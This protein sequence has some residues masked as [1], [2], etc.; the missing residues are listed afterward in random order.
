[1]TEKIKHININEKNEILNRNISLSSVNFNSLNIDQS[2]GDFVV[3]DPSNN[4]CI[5]YKQNPNN[6]LYENFE[7]S[8]FAGIGTLKTPIQ[9]KIDHFR[10]MIWIINLESDSVFKINKNKLTLETVVENIENP[11][12]ISIN[13]NNGNVYVK[14]FSSETKGSIY[15]LNPDGKILNNFEFNDEND[16]Y[17]NQII[18]NIPKSDTM[19]FENSEEKLIW[20]AETTIYTLDK[21]NKN[22]HSFI[23]EEYASLYCVGLDAKNKNV[24]VFGNKDDKSYLILFDYILDSV[25]KEE[26]IERSLISNL[27][28]ADE[29][30]IPYH[31][32]TVSNYKNYLDFNFLVE[33]G[34]PFDGDTFDFSFETQ[35]NKYFDYDVL[36][37]SNSVSEQAG[38]VLISNPLGSESVHESE[39]YVDIIS[40]DD[41][42]IK[43][44]SLRTQEENYGFSKVKDIFI[45]PKFSWS[46][47]IIFEEN[48][49]SEESLEMNDGSFWAS[50]SDNKIHKIEYILSS[51]S[52]SST[53]EMQL[54]GEIQESKFDK[55]GGCLYTSTRDY[56]YKHSIDHYFRGNDYLL[57][58]KEDVKKFNPNSDI[59]SYIDKAEAISVQKYLGNIARRDPLTLEIKE[60][61]SGFGSPF[62]IR[63]SFFHKSYLIGCDNSIWKLNQNYEREIVYGASD[64]KVIDFDVSET[65]ETCIILEKNNKSLVRILDYSFY[66]LLLAKESDYKFKHCKYCENGI[67]Y[68][69]EEVNSELESYTSNHY[70]FDVRKKEEHKIISE[71]VVKLEDSAV[72]TDTTIPTEQIEIVSPNGGEY[73][74][75]EQINE[76]KWKSTESVTD[77]VRIDLY[78]NDE[79][80][81]TISEETTNSG[82][83]SWIPDVSLEISSAYKIK[84]EWLG[85]GINYSDISENIFSIT[86][87]KPESDE[88]IPEIESVSDIDYI[89]KDKSV[90]IVLNNGYFGL[91]NIEEKTFYGLIDSGIRG[92][93][94]IDALD[95]TFFDFNDGDIEKLR[96]WVGSDLNLSDKWDSGE[97]EITNNQKSIYYGGGNNLMAGETY[98]VNL[99]LYSNIHGWSEVQTKQWTMP[100]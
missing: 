17:L 78:K 88:I 59:V 67:F 98:Y 3:A 32:F 41:R 10:G 82:V 35:T 64:Y 83:F 5:Y 87:S 8:S 34:K 93:T 26:E 27:D 29:N 9:A 90:I 43:E 6:N 11:Y 81:L 71:N 80:L 38:D 65:G 13:L 16:F 94:S 73:F 92:I 30:Y 97:I 76:I 1:M 54:D 75:K 33:R 31:I 50:T 37:T 19:V 86:D 52:A 44:Y 68:F 28:Y 22:I 56:M 20:I 21:K 53:Y 36:L 46:D 99:Q 14:S 89:P 95:E 79:Y 15:E 84:I 62:K 2:K 12:D 70:L 58:V 63:Y 49:S 4:R 91:L 61:Y 60:L 42:G 77:F 55:K 45:I 57:E 40:K 96:I 24:F 51:N 69:I 7:I 39:F 18:E 25:I 74:I 23:F 100:K 85:A 48:E 66:K 72:E 47:Q